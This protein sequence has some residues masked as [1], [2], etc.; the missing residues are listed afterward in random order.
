M[1]EYDRPIP[2]TNIYGSEIPGGVKA[3]CGVCGQQDAQRQATVVNYQPNDAGE[4]FRIKPTQKIIYG[5]H[6]GCRSTS[7][8]S[9]IPP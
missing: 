8:V 6:S 2:L 5:G 1:P 7:T 3:P 9:P 4:F